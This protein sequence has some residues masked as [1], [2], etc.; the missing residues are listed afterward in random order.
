[1]GG[2]GGGIVESKLAVGGGVDFLVVYPFDCLVEA[3]RVSCV[4]ELEGLF[5]GW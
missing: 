1:M 3:F 4:R 2:C 5:V